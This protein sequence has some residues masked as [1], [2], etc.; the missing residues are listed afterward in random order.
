MFLDLNYHSFAIHSR[1]ITEV[2]IHMTSLH[3]TAMLINTQACASSPRLRI[4]SILI[5]SGWRGGAHTN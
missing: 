5:A 1:N 3:I 4:A 2:C